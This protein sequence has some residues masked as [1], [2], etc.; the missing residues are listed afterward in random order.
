[1]NP[2]TH[3]NLIETI[4]NIT[5]NEKTAK[6]TEMLGGAAQRAARER[7]AEPAPSNPLSHEAKLRRIIAAPAGSSRVHGRYSGDAETGVSQKTKANIGVSKRKTLDDGSPNPNYGKR[8]HRPPQESGKAPINEPQ[9]ID[10]PF[11]VSRTG[12]LQINPRGAVKGTL[13][14]VIPVGPASR[15]AR[16][17]ITSTA[18]AG[19]KKAITPP[20]I[21]HTQTKSKAK[22]GDPDFIDDTI[23]EIPVPEK[24]GP[25]P[26]PD[27]HPSSFQS[28]P[29]QHYKPGRSKPLDQA[30]KAAVRDSPNLKSADPQSHQVQ[31]AMKKQTAYTETDFDQQRVKDLMDLQQRRLE[32]KLRKGIEQLPPGDP[33]RMHHPDRPLNPRVGPPRPRGQRKPPFSK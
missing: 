10:S 25:E 3:R 15:S 30:R 19:G 4:D 18:K 8:I 7:L 5:L 32:D 33:R 24:L 20:K 16:A 28:H 22:P 29:L 11:R 31:Q 14:S 12:D 2:N 26:R 21:K 9:S 13:A 1:M 27:R 17:A 6:G 23:D